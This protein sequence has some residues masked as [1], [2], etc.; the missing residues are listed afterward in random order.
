MIP[1]GTWYS[2]LF[3]FTMSLSFIHVDTY[4]CNSF[5]F[6]VSYCINTFNLAFLFHLKLCHNCSPSPVVFWVWK[7]LCP[8]LPAW[9]CLLP[10][11]T[12][13]GRFP[14]KPTWSISH[15]R[16]HPTNNNSFWHHPAN[17]FYSTCCLFC[18]F[19]YCMVLLVDCKFSQVRDFAFLVHLCILKR[20]VTLVKCMSHYRYSTNI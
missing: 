12:V 7:F 5:L 11:I 13:Q 3:L 8:S 20:C 4:Q 10:Q 2:L 16:H 6:S 18:L 14:D 17:F 9:L 1:W 15:L 19:V